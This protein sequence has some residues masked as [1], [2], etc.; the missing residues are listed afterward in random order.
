[1]ASASSSVRKVLI[2]GLLQNDTGD[3]KA[4]ADCFAEMV[5]LEG[6][7][8]IR[9]DARS[10]EELL[11]LARKQSGKF[12]EVMFAGHS[13]FHTDSYAP[14]RFEERRLGGLQIS[15]VITCSW[16]CITLL[17]V[18][19]ISFWCCEVATRRGTHA[20]RSVAGDLTMPMYQGHLGNIRRRIRA[21]RYANV[22][23]LELICNNIAI[24]CKNSRINK[25]LTIRGL[26]G[27]GYI[28][29]KKSGGLDVKTIDFH[30]VALIQERN[31]AQKAVQFAIKTKQKTAID[32]SQKQ[33]AVCDQRVEDEIA[34]KSTPHIISFQLNP[35]SWPVEL[36]RTDA[37]VIEDEESV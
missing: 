4:M 9:V 8:P 22:S 13:R 30:H 23:T 32:K 35:D 26:N 24:L 36:D 1:M 14:T 16:D 12:S 34:R 15:D 19:M 28:G 3:M 33:F 10:R 20:G 11:A 18:D 6:G 31:N 37:I 5:R 7:N 27:V 2:I 21:N 29:K 17:K 25:S